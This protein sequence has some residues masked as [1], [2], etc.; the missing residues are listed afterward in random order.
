VIVDTP[1]LLPVTDPVVLARALDGIVV[2]VAAN[3]TP[4]K[5]LEESLNLLDSSKVLGIVFNKDHR[6]LYGYYSGDYRTRFT[7]QAARTPGA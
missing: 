6:P 4:R 5:L 2:V 1:P 7:K 3:N